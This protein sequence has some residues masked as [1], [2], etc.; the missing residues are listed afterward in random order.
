[1]VSPHKIKFN[2]VFSDTGLGS[3]NIIIDVAFDSDDGAMSTY[4]NRSAVASESYDGRY[5]NTTRYKYDE[6][7]SPQF[8]I[9]KQ[10]FS[11][12]TQDE[13]RKV[14]KYLTSTDKPALLEVYYANNDVVNWACIGGW[15]S[16]ET[17]KIANSRTVGIVAQFEA[18][19]PYAMSRLYSTTKTISSA[20][21]NTISIDIDNDDN[22]PVFPRITINHGYNPDT[23]STDAISHYIVSLPS[24]IDFTSITDMANYVEN[25][26][27]Y[28]ET[29]DTYYYKSYTPT[30]TSSATLPQYVNWTT[31]EVDHAYTSSDTFADNTFYHYAANNK[32]YWKLDDEIQEESA[33]P[34]YGDWKTKDGTKTYTATDTFEDKT[35]YSYNGTYY[36]MAPYN[37]YKSSTQPTLSTTSVKLTNV[38]TSDLGVTTTLPSVVVK[39]NSTTEKITLDGA[40]KVIYSNNTRR[41][42][43]DDFVNWQWPEL[44]DGTNVITVEGN[45]DVTIEYRTVQKIGEY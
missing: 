29:S 11:Y 24:G 32:Y 38:H 15:T 3:L 35:I 44:R 40:N 12:F 28:N 21:D 39:N 31:S 20:T 4:L 42:F 16:I 14:L 5:R 25:T 6:L 41:I 43:G 10:D 22:N 13:V 27:Y 30:F 33:L 17:Y 19:T 37:F 9:V 1:M 23:T 45:C 7:F 36:W 18:I 26:V 2:N 8:T 34:V